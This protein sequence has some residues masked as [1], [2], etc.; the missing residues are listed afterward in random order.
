MD[1]H[2]APGVCGND[3]RRWSEAWDL[4]DLNTGEAL[5]GGGAGSQGGERQRDGA[6]AVDFEREAHGL[7][8]LSALPHSGPRRRASGRSETLSQGILPVTLHTGRMAIQRPDTI[9]PNALP[10]APAACGAVRESPA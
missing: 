5:S 1:I 9:P 6:G 7:G 4:I 8:S 3:F 2:G 10:G